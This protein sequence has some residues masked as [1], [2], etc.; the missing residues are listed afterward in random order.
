MLCLVSTNGSLEPKV[1]NLHDMLKY[2]LAH[3]EDVVTRRTQY[4]LNKAQ[5][6]AHILE[7]LLKALDNIDE[8]IRIIR[9]SRSVQIARQ[10]LMDRFE[11]TDVQAQAIVDMRLRAL[12]GLEREKLET[13]YA[14]LMEKIRK[15]KAIL[16]D[17]NLLLR[18][19]RE[20]MLEISDKYGDD[21]KTSLG[22]D[23]DEITVEDL[24]KR[25]NTVIAMTQLGYIK[26]MTMDNFRSQNRG[27][28]GIKGMTKLDEDCITELMMANT[29]DY[30]LFFTNKGRV[31][32]LK[33]YEIPEASRIARGTALINLLQLEPGEK[34]TA[35]IP[36]EKYENDK[37]LFMATKNGMVKKTS[38]MEYIN[39]R[40]TGLLA[41]G[42]REDDELIEV[43]VTDKSDLIYLV[44][45]K[46]MS[47]CFKQDN[48]RATGRTSMGVIGMDL[49]ADDLIVGM[50]VSSQG[51]AVLI[52]SE[53]GL[54]KRTMLEEFNVQNRGGKGLKCY[55]ITDKTGLVVGVKCVNAEDE[56][57]I[58]TTGGIIIRMPVEGISILKRIT[59]GVK[60]IQLDEGSVVAS[61]AK[62]REDMKDD[63]ETSVEQAEGAEEIAD[64]SE[65]DSVDNSEENEKE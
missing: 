12:T 26:R 47:I 9:G 65:N 19:I 55:K 61:I 7:G 31:F 4:D 50:Q 20:E 23:D 29:H 58:I 25:E 17:R 27:G 52:V 46:G 43:K 35:T 11:L 37:Y 57:M 51:E 33:G 38:I 40:K 13:E 15:L 18:V 56:L 53:K 22:V 41:I 59:S 42:L 64:V 62:I 10:E 49:D 3:Q 39:V 1:L 5:E 45:Q 8:V 28:R 54:G 60:L 24:I 30:I 44:S 48:V 14:E 16:E 2:Y 36:L 21:R 63:E 32:R 34:V 6:R